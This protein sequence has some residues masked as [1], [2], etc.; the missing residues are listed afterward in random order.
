MKSHLIPYKPLSGIWVRGVRKA[1][2]QF[3]RERAELI[4]KAFEHE[5]GTKLFR[6]G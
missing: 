2:R 5:A 3:R 6:T 4:C 1:Y